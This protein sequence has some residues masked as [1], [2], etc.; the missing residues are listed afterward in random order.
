MVE[1]GRGNEVHMPY[2]RRECEHGRGEQKEILQ[3][4]VTASRRFVINYGQM[5]A[6]APCLPVKQSANAMAA[7]ADK[8]GS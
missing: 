5:T 4:A 2:S 3:C 7:G 8:M 6:Q 1:G